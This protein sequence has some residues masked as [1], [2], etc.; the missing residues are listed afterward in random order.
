[1]ILILNHSV[2]AD[3]DTQMIL[4]NLQIT[5]DLFTTDLTKNC[6]NHVTVSQAV[7]RKQSVV[8]LFSKFFESTV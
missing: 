7:D 6:L 5:I 1:V 8:F 3:F 4:T 2:T